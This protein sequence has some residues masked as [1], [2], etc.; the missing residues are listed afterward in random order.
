MS[1]NVN[2][3]DVL[4]SLRDVHGRPIKDDVEVIF[5]NTQVGSLSQGFNLRLD[6]SQDP[7]VLSGV[8]AFPT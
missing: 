8:P 4:V 2:R 6:G 5:K 7:V 3:A 1:N